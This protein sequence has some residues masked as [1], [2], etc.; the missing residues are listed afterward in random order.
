MKTRS[1]DVVEKQK[2][3]QLISGLTEFHRYGVSKPIELR[4]YAGFTS[5]LLL[6]NDIEGDIVECGVGRGKSLFYIG[7]LTY[8]LKSKKRI[9]G[10]DSF[11]GFP[12][13]TEEDNSF[14]NPQ[15]GDW[16][17]ANIELVKN[18]F[19][20]ADLAEFYE[21]NVF[22]VK[23]F[24]SDTIQENLPEV[25]SFLHLDA[26]LYQSTK[27]VIE[28]AYLRLSKGAYVVFDEYD[29]PKWPGVKKAVDEFL[30]DKVEDVIFF[31]LIS[32]YGFIK[33]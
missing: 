27:D 20:F 31:E 2:A 5:L 22:L 17:F 30:F 8:I 15:K 21:S 4:R 32:R 10:F 1:K 25:I 19:Y 33:Q 13:P 23:G 26:D 29:E 3:I 16:S 24:F 6:T 28:N 11:E 12:E 9:F 7:Y 14:R 18:R